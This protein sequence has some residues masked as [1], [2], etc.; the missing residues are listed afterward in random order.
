MD[1][2]KIGAF[3]KK[4]G[5]LK[6]DGQAFKIPVVYIEQCATHILIRLENGREVSGW[7]E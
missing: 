4:A 5:L 1:Y 3:C 2:K 7:L 6:K